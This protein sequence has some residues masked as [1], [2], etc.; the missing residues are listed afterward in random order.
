[1]SALPDSAAW[2]AAVAADPVLAV[3][4]GAWSFRFAIASGNA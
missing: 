4:A 2:H 3:W 1:M